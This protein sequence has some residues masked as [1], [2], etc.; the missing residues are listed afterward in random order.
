MLTTAIGAPWRD[1]SAVKFRPRTIG[2]PSAL[3]YVDET[4]LAQVSSV[5][6]EPFPRHRACR[7][8]SLA[9]LSTCS[10][11]ERVGIGDILNFRQQANPIECELS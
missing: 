10:E 4:C 1:S 5:L 8:E 2:I 9:E 7:S 3:K 11:V 6:D